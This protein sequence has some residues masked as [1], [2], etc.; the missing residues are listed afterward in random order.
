MQKF[1]MG[2][3][4]VFGSDSTLSSLKFPMAYTVWNLHYPCFSIL[5]YYK[6]FF[7]EWCVLRHSLKYSLTSSS[8][9]SVHFIRDTMKQICTSY[10][11]VL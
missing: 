10:K 1:K 9:A 5:P 2:F 7:L 8:S 4:F 11:N 3:I 6:L